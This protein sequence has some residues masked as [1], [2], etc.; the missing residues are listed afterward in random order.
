MFGR[1]K[2]DRLLAPGFI[3]KVKTR[4]RII[5]TAAGTRYTHNEDLH[6]RDVARAYYEALARGGVGL[7]IVES[8]A[9]D[10]SLGSTTVNRFRI[11]DDKYLPVFSELATAI[12]QHGCP[13]FYSFTIPA[14]GTSNGWTACSP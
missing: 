5:K 11:D 3:G 1:G 9:V 14:P 8:P 6:L 2:F 13:T 4:N 10:Y 7:L 12:H